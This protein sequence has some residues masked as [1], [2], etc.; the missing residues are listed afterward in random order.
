MKHLLAIAVLIF[1]CLSAIPAIAGDLIVSRMAVKDLTGTLTI[2][3]ITKSEATAFKSALIIHIGESVHWVRLRVR[4]PDE[5]GKVVLFIRPTYINNITLYQ[6][7]PTAPNGW[8]TRTTGNIH[9]FS[10]RDRP[11]IS[12]GFLIDVASPEET[13]Y[14]RIEGERHAVLNVEA[15]T[16]AEADQKDY[17]RDLLI[18]FF[19]T[20][21]ATLFLWSIHAYIL[22]RQ[23]VFALF[24]FHQLVYTLFGIATVG[25]LA[26]FNSAEHPWLVDFITGVMYLSI[27]PTVL[28]FC[29]ELIKPY[30]P[31]RYIIWGLRAILSIFALDYVL[32][33]TEYHPIAYSINSINL[34]FLLLYLVVTSFLL[35]KEH[36][37]RRSTIQFMLLFIFINNT[38]FW[39]PAYLFPNNQILKWSSI[40]VLFVDG[41]LIALLFA[42]VSFV[43]AREVRREA[44][45]ATQA[46]MAINRT[47]LEEKE[48]KNQA[49]TAARTDYLTGLFNRRHFFELAQRELDRSIRYQRLFTLLMIDIDHFK[50]INDTWGHAFG[51]TVL[52]TV[53]NII[54][55]TLRNVDLFG[56]TGGEEFAAVIVETE[57][58]ESIDIA[59][60]L[61]EGVEM[62]SAFAPDGTEVRV[63]ISIGITHLRGREIEFD[64][65]MDEADQAMYSAKKTGRNRIMVNA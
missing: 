4:A 23:K 26:P 17:D 65:V 7:D 55:D 45:E 25:Y 62:C 41:F 56:R 1:G 58:S 34:K 16:P 33:A 57:E 2:D 12:L 28:F 48:L 21:M 10:E 27:G 47:L 64:L 19:V 18:V 39:I 14:L 46:V 9:P 61:R 32:L 20:S 63:T 54:N 5:N 59:Q 6:A 29:H 15:L 50:S 49:E 40:Q 24:A 11:K 8:K 22:D 37:P 35:R 42:V 44:H 3:D 13:V 43:R 53:A 31:P 60:R 36:S 30:D 51:D 38:A 52:R